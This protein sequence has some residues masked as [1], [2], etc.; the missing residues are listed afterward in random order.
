[1][2]IHLP[3]SST[4]LMTV[5]QC[6]SR[7]DFST[8]AILSTT[9]TGI[10][11]RTTIT[12]VA[13][14]QWT[15]GNLLQRRMSYRKIANMEIGNVRVVAR[16]KRWHCGIETSY[17]V[18]LLQLFS[19]FFFLS[20]SSVVSLQFLENTTTA[21]TKPFTRFIDKVPNAYDSYTGNK[22]LLFT[23]GARTSP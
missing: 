14:M 13:N 7:V 1:M 21:L 16:S 19:V 9:F 2:A 4:M 10:G 23:L 5:L 22:M 6:F 20:C 17:E 12:T 18:K 3:S 11:E 15:V 8:A